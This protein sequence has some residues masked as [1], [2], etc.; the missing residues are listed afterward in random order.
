MEINY[1]LSYMNIKRLINKKPQK[2]FQESNTSGKK[3]SRVIKT[4]FTLLL[5]TFL[6]GE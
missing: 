6:A 1:L 4:Y 5:G 2:L 3:R